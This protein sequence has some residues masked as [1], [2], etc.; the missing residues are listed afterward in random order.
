MHMPRKRSIRRIPLGKPKRGQSLV[1]FAI[2]S[3]VLFFL[4]MSI[5]DLARLLFT[6][7]VITNA[8]QE[9]T[10]YGIVRP[11]EVVPNSLVTYVAGNPTY[12]GTPIPTQIV[13]ANSP[14]DVVDKTRDKV[15]GI[16][17]S[18]VQIAFWYD[19]G[20]GT[21]LPLNSLDDLDHAATFGNRIDVQ[22]SYNFQFTVP[23]LS[24]FTPNGINVRMVSARTLRTRGSSAV[25]PCDFNGNIAPTPNI[26]ATQTTIA[27]ITQTAVAQATAT[28][29]SFWTQTAV[30]QATATAGNFTPTATPSP[31]ACT[32]GAVVISNIS[33]FIQNTGSGQPL[34]IRVHVQNNCGIPLPAAVVTGQVYASG[35]PVGG[36]VT[37][38]N[39]TGGDYGAC[40]IGSYDG[41]LNNLTITINAVNL[42]LAPANATGNISGAST[43]P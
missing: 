39:E 30:A 25:P 27:Q 14:C 42:P 34:Q 3:I 35:T 11:R 16:S 15:I 23:F 17:P 5:I 7:A 1:E 31:T 18:D 6:Y 38:P 33:A 10:R 2:I 43:C 26:G 4:I 40:N 21:P 24:V 28:T 36:V 41:R 9:G 22:T 12:L 29:G 8:A 13:V 32:A 19:A 37:L 20:D